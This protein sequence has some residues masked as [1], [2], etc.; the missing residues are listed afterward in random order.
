MIGGSCF[1]HSIMHILVRL[2]PP[3]HLSLIARQVVNDDGPPSNHHSPYIK[4]MVA[5]LQEHG[6]V[7]SVVLPDRQRSWIG[8]AHLY[9]ET[10]TPSYYR[11]ESGLV[12][13]KPFPRPLKKDEP[14][15]EWVLVD[16]TPAA[17]V[18]LGLCHFY[19]DRGPVDL[20]LSGPNYG[21]NTSNLFQLASG[22]IGG[23]MEAVHFRKRAIAL[24]FAYSK[25]DSKDNLQP[26]INA[27]SRHAVKIIDHLYQNWGSDVEL[28][29]VNVPVKEDVEQKKTLFTYSFVNYWEKS[30]FDD[31]IQDPTNPMIAD[32]SLSDIT[33]GSEH[34]NQTGNAVSTHSRHVHRQFKFKPKLG[35]TLDAAEKSE[36][37]NDGHTVA[38]EMSRYV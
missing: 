14:G 19:Q 6:H 18:H 3:A 37:G 16:S 35:Y 8:K 34:S 4:T 2:A 5:T 31:Q 36:P 9:G 17:C 22:T 10:V 15:E 38:H 13:G 25:N 30:A 11:P 26:S 21:R 24:S 12:D 20:V 27:A 32:L 33:N 1:L 28:Y 29:T 7:V 23:A